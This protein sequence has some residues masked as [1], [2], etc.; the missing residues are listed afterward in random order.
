LTDY[1]KFV[2]IL[3]ITLFF[4]CQPQKNTPKPCEKLPFYGI[5]GKEY[6]E[7][8]K[9]HTTVFG[10]NPTVVVFNKLCLENK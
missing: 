8:Y 10:E 2:I 5:C 7:T 4:G 1:K 3:S 9:I 6:E